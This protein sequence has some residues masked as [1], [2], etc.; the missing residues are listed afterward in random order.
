MV[1][2]ASATIPG[3]VV[4]HAYVLAWSRDALEELE[5]VVGLYAPL[6]DPLAQHVERCQVARVRGV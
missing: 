2:L 6:F 4:S 5:V 1:L 3:R